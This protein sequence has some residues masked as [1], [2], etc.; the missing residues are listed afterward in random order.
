MKEAEVSTKSNAASWLSNLF[1]AALSVVFCFVCLELAATIYL[2]KFAKTETF[3]R[4]AS[5][6]Q[7]EQR[8]KKNDLVYFRK[9]FHR[10]LGY[11]LTPNYQNGKN[12]HNSLAY[13]GDEIA[14][15]KP[16]DEFRIVCLGGSTTYTSGVD[17][18]HQSYPDLLEQEILQRGY[19][20][21]NVINAGVPGWTSWECLINFELRV[22]DLN[23]DI[24]IFYEAINDIHTRL[25][26]PPA[27]YRGDNS[28]T[29]VPAIS[30]LFMPSI[31]EYS[32]LVRFVL[33]RTG[34]N[35]P[36][37]D[38][39]NTIDHHAS[40]FYG[41]NFQRQKILDTYPSGIFKSVSASKML[42]ANPP[43]YY[44][45]NVENI[46]LIAKARNIQPVLATFT[47]SPLFKSEPRVA[48]EEYIA[49]YKEMNGILK[50]IAEQQGAYLFDLASG[51]PVDKKYY[52]DGR[53]VNEEG[54]RL[55]AKLFA[56]YL[57][58]NNLIPSARRH[59]T[60]KKGK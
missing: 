32:T 47:Y 58:E 36:H 59:F 52:H 42:E 7:L 43:I 49:A 14:L 29:S 6:R 15:P 54:A 35:Q 21:V 37:A 3:L 20:N 2:E 30:N 45:R 8:F 10:Y 39:S 22:L 41:D 33:V 17:D 12:K 9:S 11:Y 40:T 24:V 5:L 60:S 50:N 31:F 1:I 26:W 25:V 38:I 53:H 28:G 4:Y 57:V 46:V 55:M 13:R 23:P 16:V 48:S 18:Y 19:M 34:V 27:A 51:F 44:Q 56:N